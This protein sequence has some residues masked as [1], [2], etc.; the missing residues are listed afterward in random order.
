VVFELKFGQG[1]C[2]VTD[3]CTGT[4]A[5]QILALSDFKVLQFFTV[6]SSV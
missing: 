6:Y 2:E 1:F 4:E 3:K 5:N